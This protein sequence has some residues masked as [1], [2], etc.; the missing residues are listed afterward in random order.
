MASFFSFLSSHFNL[1]F[2]LLNPAYAKGAALP[3]GAAR[4]FEKW[5]NGMGGGFTIVAINATHS[6]GRIHPFGN[7][8]HTA[9]HQQNVTIFFCILLGF[10]FGFVFFFLSV[11]CSGLIGSGWKGLGLCI[12]VNVYSLPCCMLV[13]L[14]VYEL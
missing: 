2:P 6:P 9:L 14:H 5:G 4:V 13:L 3:T 1:F 10:S 7:V 12:C 8:L 11:V